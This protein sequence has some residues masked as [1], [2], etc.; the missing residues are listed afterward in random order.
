MRNSSVAPNLDFHMWE[1]V[2]HFLMMEKPQQF[3]EAVIVFL[4]KNSL[5]K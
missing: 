1:G 3:N 5:L 2:G 4:N